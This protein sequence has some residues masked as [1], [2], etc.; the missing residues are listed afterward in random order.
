MIVTAPNKIILTEKKMGSKALQSLYPDA[1]T[2]FDFNNYHLTAPVTEDLIRKVVKKEDSRLY[3]YIRKPN[4]KLISGIT[5]AIKS[6]DNLTTRL[7]IRHIAPQLFPDPVDYLTKYARSNELKNTYADLIQQAFHILLLDKHLSFNYYSYVNYLVHRLKDNIEKITFID[8]DNTTVENRKY[9]EDIKV[10]NPIVTNTSFNIYDIFWLD[11]GNVKPITENF[12]Q[13][14][15][16][17]WSSLKLNYSHRWS[18]NPD[19]I[20]DTSRS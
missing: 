2:N 6:T 11:D 15:Q 20:D 18:S 17:I 13:P 5:Q 4:R 16:M 7:T 8:I 14:F 9:L 10:L 3:I 1:F 12:L 19:Y